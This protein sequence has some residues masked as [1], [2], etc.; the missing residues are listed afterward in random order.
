MPDT[1]E[2]IVLPLLTE[3]LAGIGGVIK[4]REEDFIVEEL[5]LYE[6]CGEGTHIYALIE[7]KG[8]STMDVL[9]KIAKALHIKR[10]AIGFAGLKDTQAI[11]RQWISIENTEPDILMRLNLSGIK[12]LQLA[13]HNNK[14]RLGHL[15]GNHF[16][17][18][19]R[20]FTLPLQ[21][22]IKQTEAILAVL[23]KRGVPNYFGPQ[24]FGSRNDGHLLGKAI[25]CG[26]IDEFM[27]IFLGRPKKDKYTAYTAARTFYERGDYEKA[28]NA[29]PITFVDQHRALK[30]LLKTS[31]DKKAA[32]NKVDRNLA[33]FYV[34]AYQSHIFNKVLAARMPL[35]DK[36]LEGDMAYKHDNGACFRV[37]NPQAEQSR[38]DAFE[39]S[40]TGPLFGRR[41]TE[42]TGPAG[43]IENPILQEAKE[44]TDNFSQL[45]KNIARGCRR[46]LRFQPKNVRIS[47]GR[48]DLGDYIELQFLLDSGCY[49]TTLLREITKSSVS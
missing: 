48:D 40:P 22:S 17:I 12:I 44:L 36:V 8:I 1:N 27:D 21:Q 39:I 14:I 34:S 45:D 2:K 28:C 5:P 18:R 23:T 4:T 26:Q 46:S 10:K 24:R 38:C 6:P 31:G 41:M 37:E 35:I 29:W 3:D 9:V 19:I 7:K 16:I 13:R 25:I 20:N 43:E 49:A 11:T 42:L 47:S 32:Y 15:S 30:E 33:R